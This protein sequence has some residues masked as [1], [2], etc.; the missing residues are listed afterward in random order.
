MSVATAKKILREGIDDRGAD[1]IFVSQSVLGYI[2]IYSWYKTER[3]ADFT[4]ESRLVQVN[5]AGI[6]CA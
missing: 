4:Y 2:R 3:F 6:Y 5:H 1:E